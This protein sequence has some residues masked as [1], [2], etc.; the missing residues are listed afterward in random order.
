MLTLNVGIDWRGANDLWGWGFDVAPA[1]AVLRA[2]SLQESSVDS[3]QQNALCGY[4]NDCV[5]AFFICVT[6]G[7]T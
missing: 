3:I 7:L 2:T 5:H 1:I 4:Y 6:S